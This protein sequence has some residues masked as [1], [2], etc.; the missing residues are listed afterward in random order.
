MGAP[1][2]I[3][4]CRAQ[5]DPCSTALVPQSLQNSDIWF[6][7]ALGYPK[8]AKLPEAFATHVVTRRGASP[9]RIAGSTIESVQANNNFG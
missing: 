3:G 7:A 5:E 8:S 9:S 2:L 6:S 1:W 4:R